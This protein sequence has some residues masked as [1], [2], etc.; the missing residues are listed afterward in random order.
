M[1]RETKRQ[2]LRRGDSPF[3]R[4]DDRAN[5][6]VST[7]TQITHSHAPGWETKKSTAALESVRIEP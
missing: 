3:K 5:V 4:W 6:N 1:F 2:N 7:W